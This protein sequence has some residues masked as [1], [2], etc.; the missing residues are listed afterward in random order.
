MPEIAGIPFRREPSG[1]RTFAQ[2]VA[3]LSVAAFTAVLH[4]SD[5]HRLDAEL[6]DDLP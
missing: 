1:Q 4:Y 3:G 5:G 2:S 6:L